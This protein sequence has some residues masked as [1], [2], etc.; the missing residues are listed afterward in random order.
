[1]K[2]KEISDTFCVMPWKGINVNPRGYYTPCCTSDFP[3]AHSN[4]VD[5]QQ[6]W[7]HPRYQEIRQKMLK[8]EWHDACHECQYREE[9]NIH[10][11]SEYVSARQNFNRDK[12]FEGVWDSLELT[13]TPPLAPIEIEVDFSNKCNLKCNMCGSHN[14][15]AWVEDE[16][17]LGVFDEKDFILRKPT[18]EEQYK[19]FLD[20]FRKV[21]LMRFKGGEPF[22][23]PEPMRILKDLLSEGDTDK[24]IHFVSN[25]TVV[26]EEVFQTL[27]Q[28]AWVD[29]E[30]SLDATGLCYQYMRGGKK[31]S[32]DHIEKQLFMI[33]K[34][35][36][37]TKSQL[38]INTV[39]QNLNAFN[40]LDFTKWI[41]QFSKNSS[42]KL[43]LIRSVLT[44]PEIYK[45]SN[46][47]AEK[48]NLA[49]DMLRESIAF[50]IDH[51]R[52]ENFVT[53]DRVERVLTDCKK[54]MEEDFSIDLWEEFKNV[55][56]RLDQIRNMPIGNYIP[57][58]TLSCDGRKNA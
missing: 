52:P 54:A 9:H 46:L 50:Q 24:R 20:A 12:V 23:V 53:Y 34:S 35:L 37:S 11:R 5:I 47:P 56:Q 30:I 25:G 2:A 58:L 26:K 4:N 15:T 36:D 7:I 32:F 43:S 48:K 1:M 38:T 33:E 27:N 57:E 21:K 41:Y 14:S 49:L 18:T 19:K 28:F 10:S 6:A 55:S 16:K 39:F 44:G 42:L 31:F 13:P 29:F 40:V 3:I 8:G 17:A 45:P 51:S 22:M